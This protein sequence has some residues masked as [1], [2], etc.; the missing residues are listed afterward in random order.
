MA[1]V[2]LPEN[3]GGF[4]NKLKCYLSC[5]ASGIPTRANRLEGFENLLLPIAFDVSGFRIGHLVGTWRT[6]VPKSLER[7]VRDKI[8]AA[9][10]PDIY[11]TT[12][13]E[14]TKHYGKDREIDLMYFKTPELLQVYYLL[15]LKQI[16][17]NPFAASALSNNPF[18]GMRIIGVS[19]RSWQNPTELDNPMAQQ[20]ALFFNPSHYVQLI[21]FVSRE[22]D[23]VYLSFD[24]PKFK[25]N[26]VGLNIPIILHP[27]ESAF[28]KM[29]CLSH[30]ELLIGDRFST[31][32]ECAW[33]LG[34]C[35][36][37]VRL[38]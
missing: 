2:L 1:T 32:L 8:Y 14:F 33:W 15:A 3:P 37:Q 36:S 26:F 12:S 10:T 34:C 35:R 17:W 25:K 22:Y 27:A 7:C 31:F 24:N 11:D 4:G 23:A 16:P 5:L 29:A 20:R 18:K 30:C 9:K 28:E 38:I 21:N 6:L 13:E 19:V